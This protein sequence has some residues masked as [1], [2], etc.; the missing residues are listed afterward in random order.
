MLT[1]N[2]P[3]N[4]NDYW[5]C[6]ICRLMIAFMNTER[7]C[8]I[9]NSLQAIIRTLDSIY[10]EDFNHTLAKSDLLTK[11]KIERI[12]RATDLARSIKFIASIFH[13]SKIPTGREMYHCSTS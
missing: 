8:K 5:Q 6:T 9:E 10:T 2:N 7:P 1:K 11:N 4:M 12:N 13:E 3:R